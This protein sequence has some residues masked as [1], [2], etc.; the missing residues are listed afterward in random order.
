MVQ[1]AR[2]GTVALV[3]RPGE[4]G[5][6]LTGALRERGQRALWWPAFDLLAPTRVE[7]LQAQLQRLAEFDL[8]VFVSAAAVLF[9]CA[10]AAFTW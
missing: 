9:A 7:P 10:T 1:A 8:V 2:R 3:T 5:Q 6:R 4:A